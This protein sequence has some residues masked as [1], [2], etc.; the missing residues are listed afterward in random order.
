[1]TLDRLAREVEALLMASDRPLS[2]ERL[3]DLTGAGLESVEQAVSRVEDALASG[4]HA[5]EIAY[6]AGGYRL[7]TDPALGTVVSRLFE[8]RRPGKLTRAALETLAV[9]AYSQPCTRAHVEAVRGVNCDSAMKTLL[10]R[11]FMAITGRMETPGRPLLYSTTPAFLEYFG[12]ARLE[13]LPR[14]DEIGNLLALGADDL[15]KA[16]LDFSKD[17]EDAH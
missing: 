13:H 6:L 9:V 11:D 2:I 12:L 4:G 10:E 1:M 7:V 16:A 14:L 5:M 17:G 15:E 3:C 8:G